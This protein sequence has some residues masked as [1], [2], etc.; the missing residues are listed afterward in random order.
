MMENIAATAATIV[1][2]IIAKISSV[3]SINPFLRNRKG[4]SFL[5]LFY[6]QIFIVLFSKSLVPNPTPKTASESCDECGKSF[7]EAGGCECIKNEECD[8]LSLIPDGCFKCGNKAME[9][10]SSQEG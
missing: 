10:C 8:Q 7:S 6:F 2:E 5:K 1:K 3:V 4:V 9:Y